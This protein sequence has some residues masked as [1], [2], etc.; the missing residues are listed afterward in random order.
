MPRTRLTRAAEVTERR[1]L[2]AIDRQ[3]GPLMRAMSRKLSRIGRHAA[4]LARQGKEPTMALAGFRREGQR[5][6]APRLAATADEGAATLT[7]TLGELETKDAESYI[8]ERS[9]WAQRHAAAQVKRVDESLRTLIRRRVSRALD[10]NT[11]PRELAK[12][13]E[14]LFTGK[15]A[16]ARAERIARTELHNAAMVG[17]HGEALRL[18]RRTGQRFVK[19]WRS[20]RD[21]RTRASHRRADGQTVPLNEPFTVGGA[22]LMHPGD[23]DGPAHEVINCFPGDTPIASLGQVRKVYRRWYEGLVV[24]IETVSG[25]KLIA[26]PKHPMFTSDGW[27]PAEQVKTGTYLVT[28][29]SGEKVV[30]L[31]AKD[32]PH[33]QQPTLAEVYSLLHV[34]GFKQGVPGTRVDFHGDGQDGNVDIV[35]DKRLLMLN[36]EPPRRELA[37]ELDFTDADVGVSALPR[38]G[39]GMSLFKGPLPTSDSLMSGGDV[40]GSL[41]VSHPAHANSVCLASASNVNAGPDKARPDR[42]SSKSILP[43]DSQ[44]AEAGHVIGH[45][46]VIGF[47]IS[48]FSGHVYNLETS[49]GYYAANDIVVSNCRCTQTIVPERAAS[50]DGQPIISRSPTRVRAQLG[51]QQLDGKPVGRALELQR[52]G[53]LGE[54]SAPKLY[55]AMAREAVNGK[56]SLVAPRTMSATERAAFERLGRRKGVQVIRDPNL[57]DGAIAAHPRPPMIMQLVS[58]VD[59]QILFNDLVAMLFQGLDEVQ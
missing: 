57:V 33:R 13:L 27:V 22:S 50:L 11:P 43:A 26:T 5:L 17:Q 45:D 39:P 1:I 3:T 8:M 40:G 52:G 55:N 25:R 59:D 24:N 46:L 56:R 10:R 23:S 20:T 15:S 34:V 54:R 38:Q 30:G 48:S 12:Q 21:P 14:G 53:E 44:F 6:L 4:I 19:V 36:A 37:N 41:L 2:S 9:A 32:E 49:S 18:Q 51:Q 16:V 35:S 58:E 42:S 47:F 7:D 31:S 29:K 28:A